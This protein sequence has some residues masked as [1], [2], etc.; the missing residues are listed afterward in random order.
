[1]KGFFSAVVALSVALGFL[2]GCS[3]NASQQL[4]AAD[5]KAFDAAAPELKQIWSVALEASK[6]NDYAGGQILF[7]K[8]LNQEL[9]PA[10]RDAVSKE[11]TA[12]NQRLYAAFEKGD[13]AAQKA[14]EEL[15]KHQR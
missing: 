14:I 7:T 13:P 12:L 6:T 1:M 11:S 4:S 10:Q 5:L 9:S 3:K 2:A 8:I 15:R